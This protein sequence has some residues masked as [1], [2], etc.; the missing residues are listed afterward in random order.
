MTKDELQQSA[1]KEA[2]QYHRCSLEIATGGGK[3]KI[4]FMYC[5]HFYS[6]LLRVLLVGPKLNIYNEWENEAKKHGYEYIFNHFEF[7]TYLSLDKCSFDYDILIMDEIH[8]I[9]DSCREWLTRYDGKILGLSGTLPRNKYSEKTK[10]V[11]EF[12][13]CVFSYGTD[14]AIADDILNDYRIVVHPLEL[15]TK[16]DLWI[17]KKSGGGW[18]TSEEANYIYWTSRVIAACSKRESQITRVMR[19][20]ALMG[21]PTKEAFAKTLFSGISDKAILFANE[22]DQVDRM[23]PFTYHSKN[24]N[25]AQYLELFRT[26]KILKLGAVQML[27]EGVNISGLRQAV[28]MHSFSGDSPKSKQKLGRLLRLNPDETAT[29]HMMYYKDTVDEE[30]LNSFLTDVDPNKIT[31]K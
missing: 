20:K 30:W 29:L 22:T 24:K 13:P 26:N 11:D 5:E 10:L 23:T 7:S 3:C 27:S 8:S 15:S 31:Y 18:M 6:D 4:G 19:M 28:I 9:T 1:L 21:F 16:K 17:A 12:A 2:V 14:T 25:S